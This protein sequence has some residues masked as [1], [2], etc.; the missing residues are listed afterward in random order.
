MFF[1]AY[2]F[3]GQVHLF[4][5]RVKVVSHSSCRTCAIFKYFCPLHTSDTNQLTESESDSLCLNWYCLFSAPVL[6]AWPLSA[7]DDWPF[8]GPW[9]SAPDII[10]Y[11]PTTEV[12][13]LTHYSFRAEKNKKKKCLK[14]FRPLDKSVYIQQFLIRPNKKICVF[15]V[16]GLKILGRV[17][18][19]IFLN[20]FF[21]LEKIK[22]YAFWRPLKRHKFISRFHK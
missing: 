16:K 21:F 1:I 20:Y 22:Y 10:R 14:Y 17:G 12:L 19:H 13:F 15:R 8:S 5:G 9:P 4:A 11:L 7:L 6:D 18:T 3:K 2:A